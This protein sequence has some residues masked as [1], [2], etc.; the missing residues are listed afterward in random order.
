M[1]IFEIINQVRNTAG[2]KAK[3]DILNFQMNEVLEQI[4]ADTYDKSRNYY[5]KKY[6]REYETMF[7]EGLTI[8]ANYDVFHN[9]LNQLNDR[10]VTGDAAVALV[11][12]TIAQYVHNE[13]EI[14]HLIMDR[15]LKIGVGMDSFNKVGGTNIDKFEVAL[16]YN[17]DK[18]KNVNPIDG[19]YYASRKLDGVR[20]VAIVDNEAQTVQFFSRQGKEFTSIDHI[21]PALLSMCDDYLGKFV[22]DGELC[23]VD[24]DGNEDFSKAVQRVTKKGVTANDVR[25][26]IF[27]FIP[28]DDFIKGS[29]TPTSPK[30]SVRHE[31]LTDMYVTH[32]FDEDGL[33]TNVTILPQ[34]LITTQEEFNHWTRVVEESGW[35]GFMLRKDAPYKSGRN[36]DLIKVK[37]FQDAEY[38]VK[39]VTYGTACYNEDGMK[40]YDVVAGL[41]I[42]HKG[43]E[44]IVG[45]GLSKGQRLMWYAD[46]SLI[47][48]KTITV[49]YFEESKNKD[50]DKLSLRF[51]VLK[52]VYEDGRCC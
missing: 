39:D 45:S 8:D 52:Y 9:M 1:K 4:F 25:Y 12:D 13:R 34:S 42:E 17:L 49:Q 10:T 2:S 19:T 50:N 46:P 23:V 33:G 41:V 3:K 48:G 22:F 35:E 15:N 28:Y 6:N 11:E 37:K 20:C 14:L 24:E 18:V 21:K 44:V 16:A 31:I 32:F 30:F 27:D 7:S 29:P 47:I 36:K 26:C 38:V 43:N 5:V 40:E 51:P